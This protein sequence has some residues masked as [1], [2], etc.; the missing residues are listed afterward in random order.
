MSAE[1]APTWP[2]A[3][4]HLAAAV[5]DTHTHLDLVAERGGPDVA[6]SIELAT[7][8]GVERAIQVGCDVAGSRWA[9]EQAA[10]HPQLMAAVAVHPNEAPRIHAATGLTG[11]E[12]AWAEI[13]RLAGSPEVCAVGETGLDFHRTAA[14]GRAIQE[15]SFRQHIGIATAAGKALVV[16]DRDAH[17]DVL[18]ILDDEAAPRA[19]IL[20]CFSGSVSH[21][22]E[23]TRRGWYCSFAGVLTFRNADE[24]RAAFLE[25]PFDRVLVETD[26]PFLT[27]APHRGKINGS[28]LMPWTVRMIAELAGVDERRACDQLRENARRAFA[29]D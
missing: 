5:I 10:R 16:H 22:R 13:A 7:E 12:A 20:H 19:I 24:L 27:P 28:Y 6:T 4:Q 25:V 9:V 14:P 8:V 2:A 26:A 21:A 23:A 3:P 11:V 1:R 15:E 29:L 18:R 17:A